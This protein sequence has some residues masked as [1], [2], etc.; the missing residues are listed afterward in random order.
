MQNVLAWTVSP[1]DDVI[2]VGAHYDHLG[3]RG[4]SFYPGADDNAS[5]VAMAL[6]MAKVIKQSRRTI[7]FILF[8]GEE[9]GL[10]GST[11]Y[12]NNPKFPIKKHIFMLNL[13]MVGNLGRGK[14]TQPLDIPE[15]LQLLYAKYPFARSVTLRGANDD[16]DNSSFRDI[17]VPFA[18]IHTGLTQVYHTPADTPDKLNYEGMEKIINYVIE[19]IQLLNTKDLPDY[20]LLGARK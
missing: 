15:I 12:V 17:G 8:S 9:E 1:L 5:G 4:R 16:S 20:N 19:L 14:A 10:W 7:L 2:V 13:D 3:Q 6:E 11:Y 18:F